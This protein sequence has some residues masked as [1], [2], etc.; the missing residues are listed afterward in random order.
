MGK[1][2]V[3]PVRTALPQSSVAL[4][5]NEGGMPDRTPSMSVMALTTG[6]KIPDAKAYI[7]A[8][9]RG[10]TVMGPIYFLLPCLSHTPSSPKKP[11]FWVC[12][13]KFLAAG[14]SFIGTLRESFPILV[15]TQDGRGQYTKKAG[16]GS[17]RK[18]PHHLSKP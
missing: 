1:I 13:R 17:R 11:S 16:W 2:A 8:R 4:L 9:G 10:E 15:R 5:L 7:G 18:T 12:Q 14:K 3:T 6:P